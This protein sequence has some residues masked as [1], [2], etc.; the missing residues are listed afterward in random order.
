MSNSAEYWRGRFSLLEEVAHKKAE[1]A[2][3][4]LEELY[5]EAQISVSREIES[6]Y[7][8]FATEN[9]ISLAEARKRLTGGQLEEFQWTV[10]Q[11]IK[12]GEQAGLR[13]AWLK[14][15]KNASAKFH[16][17]RLEA[18]QIGIQQ[19]I[20]RL[21]GNQTD[22]LDRL[23]REVAGSGYTHAAYEVQRG[24]GVG[25]DIAALDQ[26]KLDALLSKPWTTD[27]RT[28]S[29]RLWLRQRELVNTL[30][31]E[32]T[33]GLLRGDS[34]QKITEKVRNTLK[35]SRNQA[36][37]LVYTET[38]Y[39]HA[40]AAEES[41]KALGVEAVEVIETLDSHTCATCRGFDGK[42]VPLSQFEPGVTVPPY[43]PNCRGTTAP[44]IDED[45]A[46]QRAAR[47]EDGKTYYVP[48]NMSYTEWE[49]AFVEGGA[50]QNIVQT[51]LLMGAYLDKT[52]KLKEEKVR[53]A[54]KKFLQSVPEENRICLQQALDGV[55]FE[56]TENASVLF[57]YS[58]SR[59][60]MLYNPTDP[61]FNRY[62]LA[63]MLTHELGHRIDYTMFVSS[64]ENEA[65]Q[66]AI[67]EAKDILA[68][69][70][71][72]LI[73]YCLKNDAR[74]FLSDVFSAICE[75]SFR[76]PAY[77]DSG[78]WKRAGN[79]EREIFANLYALEAYQES[80]LLKF[81]SMNFSE[82]YQAFCNIKPKAGF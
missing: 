70:S 72:E 29:E 69:K 59:D 64:W 25:W 19:Q 43:H 10:E 39:A 44:A 81:F 8:R 53:E 57:G 65:F 23:L 82:V 24:I 5:R 47:G 74:G 49:E 60:V 1:R 6:W 20:E 66:K 41:Y 56:K 52:G 40:L 79:K 28:F 37:R 78:Y 15:L 38:A 9:K 2:V 51:S 34:T 71:K 68:G 4:E 14:K 75:D 31:K 27:G 33:Q 67:T 62:D 22:T 58:Q 45:F 12:V 77:H 63:T 3:R 76:F 42:I 50:K 21:Y 16:I 17:S 46:G 26:A 48:A 7:G 54:Y 61:I 32:L 80:E 73:E 55:E 13:A 11:Y 30:Q 18:I 36:A 35:V